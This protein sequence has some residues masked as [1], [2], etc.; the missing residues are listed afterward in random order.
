MADPNRENLRGIPSFDIVLPIANHKNVGGLRPDSLA[1]EKQRNRARFIYAVIARN[2]YREI[3]SMLSQHNIRAVTAVAGDESSRDFSRGEKIEQFPATGI[4]LRFLS[5]LI[6]MPLEDFRG[7]LAI[8]GVHPLHRLQDRL[9]SDPHFLLDLR[10]IKLQFDERSVHVEE[11]GRGKDLRVFFIHRRFSIFLD[12]D[13]CGRY[14]TRMSK[15]DSRRGF[16][17]IEILVVIAIIAILMAILLPS[18]E[19]IRHEAY[20]DD[21]GNHLRQIGIAMAVYANEN[22]GNY[23]RTNYLPDAPLTKGTGITARDPFQPGGPQNN[24]ITAA[25]FLLMRAEHL[26]GVI[27]I[28][29]YDDEFTYVPETASAQNQSNFTNWTVS[30][31]YSFADPYPSSAALGAG[32]RLDNHVRPDFPLAADRNPGVK[33]PFSDATAA[34][35]GADESTMEK[36]NSINHEREG[37]NVLFADGHVSFE[38]TPLC[39]ISGDNIYTNQSNQIDASPISQYDSVL[40]PGN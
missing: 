21:C 33:P 8:G 3:Q 2:H 1:G 12:A 28:C 7:V 22:R 27:F 9:R 39:G 37:Q 15:G 29:P 14:H 6:L 10:E 23:P 26:P 18:L 11:N 32:Y 13:F 31:G 20:I 38:F 35:P 17:I 16:T 19:H 25:I 34:A 40:L 4:Q 30:L 24:D 5:R 36:A